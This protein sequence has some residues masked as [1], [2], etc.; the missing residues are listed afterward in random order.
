MYSIYSVEIKHYGAK[1]P[2]EAFSS[3]S[4]GK[5][6]PLFPSLPRGGVRGGVYSLPLQVPQPR[7]QWRRDSLL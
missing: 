2:K 7:S 4:R 1:E 6:S 3:A 5:T